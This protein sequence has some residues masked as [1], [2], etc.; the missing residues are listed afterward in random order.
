M[1]ETRRLKSVSI[2]IQTIFISFVLSRKSLIDSYWES[3]VKLLKSVNSIIFKFKFSKKL[4]LKPHYLKS[5]LKLWQ[6]IEVV[7]DNYWQ[8]S[9]GIRYLSINFD[10]DSSIKFNNESVLMRLVI[11]K[12][13]IYWKFEYCSLIYINDWF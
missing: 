7:T 8:N 1:I 2:F 4:T 3:S 10:K 12:T 13:F 5:K 6:N 11:T 9:P